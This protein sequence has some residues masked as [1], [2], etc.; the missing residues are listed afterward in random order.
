MTITAAGRP[1]PTWA[2][3]GTQAGGLTPAESARLLAN[4]FQ[5]FAVSTLAL[6]IT[7]YGIPA[8]QGSKRHIGHGRLIEQSKAVR[9]WRAAVKAAAE[10]A[11][12]SP[13]TPLDGPIRL[14]VLFTRRRPAS[15]PKRRRAWAATSPDLDK[16][17]RST[18]D[19]L[20]DARV[21]VDDGRVVA[22]NTAKVLVGEPGALDQPGALIRVWRLHE[23]IEHTHGRLIALDALASSVAALPG[24]G[25]CPRCGEM[26]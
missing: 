20:T 8:A 15:A 23:N 22:I 1:H 24:N 13:W 14:D 21:W 7:A 26:P 2:G 19:A 5:T 11:M 17:L 3:E 16:Y 10:E 6:E 25:G 4:M 9:P 12:G 18:G